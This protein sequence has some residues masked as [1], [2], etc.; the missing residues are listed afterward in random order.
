[1]TSCDL[2]LVNHTSPPFLLLPPPRLP[3]PTLFPYTTLFRSDQRGLEAPIDLGAEA[4]GLVATSVAHQEPRALAAQ[5]EVRVRID[6]ERGGRRDSG[7]RKR[8][9]H[10]LVP[11]MWAHGDIDVGEAADDARPGA[12]RDDGGPRRERAGGGGDAQHA[13]ALAQEAV[14]LVL[15]L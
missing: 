6:D 1:T 8:G 3:R 11:P 9:R 5:R 10:E 7:R 15:L 4:V 14:N 12:R 2:P 13:V